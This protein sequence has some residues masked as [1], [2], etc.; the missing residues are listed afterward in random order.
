[1]A[2]EPPVDPGDPAG[3][4]PP[5]ADD[6][7]GL[8]DHARKLVE[9][10]NSEAAA[11][12]RDARTAEDAR[13]K[14]EAELAEFRQAQESEA[15]RRDREAEQRGYDKAIG[16]LTPR[17]LE[18]V[19][20][21]VAAGRLRDPTDAALIPAR[22]RQELLELTDPDEQRRQ[23]VK[24]IDQ[25][26]EAKPH[27]AAEPVNDRAGPLVTQGGRSTQPSRVATDPDEWLRGRR[28]AR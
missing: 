7:E 25:L 24:A 18:S 6:L 11:R 28:G 17:L 23:A 20:I 22:T 3:S 12:R 14:L 9:R 8:D 27:L 21:G 10:A 2:D 19:L 13:A 4:D 5:A 26:V 1:V 15:E 16:E